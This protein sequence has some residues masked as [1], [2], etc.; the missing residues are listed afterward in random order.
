MTKIKINEW[1]ELDPVAIAILNLVAAQNAVQRAHDLPEAREDGE[2]STDKEVNAAYDTRFGA[3]LD[4]L[5]ASLAP[6]YWLKKITV[7]R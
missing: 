5:K 1:G 3:V 4:V 2:F 6:G 7:A